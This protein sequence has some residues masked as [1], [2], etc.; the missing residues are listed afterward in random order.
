[1]KKIIIIAV[2]FCLMA[3]IG[4]VVGYHAGRNDALIEDFKTYNG[5]LIGYYGLPGTSKV[6]L[7]DF[8][9]ARYYYFANR[10]PA[11]VLGEPHDYGSVDFNSLSI[12]K[13]V[14][15]PTHEYELFKARNLISKKSI[16]ASN[17]ATNK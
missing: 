16:E 7:K 14:T 5:D 10:V 17:G 15:T 8:L 4:V 9:R 6:E 13:D 1:M 12:G 3:L 2:A 11:S